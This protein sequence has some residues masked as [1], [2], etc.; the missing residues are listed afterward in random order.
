MDTLDLCKETPLENIY[1][2]R[3]VKAKMDKARN[4]FGLTDT[5]I[6]PVVN[7]LSDDQ[8][9]IITKDVLALQALDNILQQALSFI[10]NN[11]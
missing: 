5:H 10:E 7:Y 3:D 1:R 4:M 11:I 8:V 9:R 2:S 6:L